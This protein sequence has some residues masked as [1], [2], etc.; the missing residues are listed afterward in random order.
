[1]AV[2]SILLLYMVAFSHTYDRLLL[3]KFLTLCGIMAFSMKQASELCILIV[4]KVY[5]GICARSVR[6]I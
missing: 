3:V 4:C 5:I 1:M 6:K 2:W